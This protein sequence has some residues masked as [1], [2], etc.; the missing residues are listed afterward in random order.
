ME[1]I[2]PTLGV[3]DGITEVECLLVETQGGHI[4]MDS[5]LRFNEKIQHNAMCMKE[6]SPG[7]AQSNTAIAHEGRDILSGEVLDAMNTGTECGYL[8]LNDFCNMGEEY[9][10][11]VEFAE[12]ITY[13]DHG[14]SEGLH[15]SVSD[16]SISPSGADT[17]MPWKSNCLRIME[18]PACQNDHLNIS[19]SEFIEIPSCREDESFV[20]E[21]SLKLPKSSALQNIGKFQDVWSS[22]S[23]QDV[24]PDANDGSLS[25]SGDFFCSSK[26]LENDKYGLM[27]QDPGDYRIHG[28]D[29]LA[30]TAARVSKTDALPALKRPRKPTQ[31]YMDE[32]SITLSR[33]PTRKRDFSSIG[34]D[35]S[36]GV[37]NH[38][39]CHVKSSAIRLPAEESS[40]RAIQV[41]F[42]SLAH[43]EFQ[44]NQ[45]LKRGVTGESK[46]Y[47]TTREKKT[48]GNC[49]ITTVH[50]K[51]RDDFAMAAVQRKRADSVAE[52]HPA[53][54]DEY[55]SKACLKIKDCY[56][57][58]AHSTG[59]DDYF[60]EDCLKRRDGH[61]I[62]S[63]RQKKR[64]DCVHKINPKERDVRVA[65]SLQKRDVCF[66][67]SRHK[68]KVDYYSTENPEEITHRRKHHTVWTIAEV[69]K[70]IDGVSQYG[71]GRWSRIKKL[72]FPTSAHRTSVD[73][74][75]KWRNLLK[76]SGIQEQNKRQGEKRRN[77]AWRPLPKPILRRVCELA[78]MYPYPKCRKPKIAHFHRVSLDGST[79]ITLRDYIRIIR[80]VNGN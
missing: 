24:F 51:K 57:T 10:L 58:Q 70:L 1:N 73:I 23:F 78:I 68:K 37:N 46:E 64:D 67:A 26:I 56:A 59:R 16:S 69:R 72:F 61:F 5:V 60:M 75:D 41:P 39:K 18:V 27:S 63:T 49:S 33:H 74:K 29:S 38:K 76:A 3:E 44:K 47:C 20:E 25:P 21:N 2:P 80:S 45:V 19:S 54:T 36:L 4:S 71:V 15:A 13:L 50:K 79:D 9:F 28:E 53:E 32:L 7:F 42:G 77:M 30:V 12:S 48:K 17:R 14:S 40:V 52:A 35:K 43:K 34:K 55:N 31:R 62:I 22:C 6:V 65:V 11:G 8:R 66:R